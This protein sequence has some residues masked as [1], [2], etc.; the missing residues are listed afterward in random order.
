MARQVQSTSRAP[1]FGGLTLAVAL[2]LAGVQPTSAIAQPANAASSDSINDTASTGQSRQQTGGIEAVPEQDEALDNARDL[3]SG[4]ASYYGDRFA[5]KPTASGEPF[6]PT[7]LTAAHR[8]LP[9]GS[10]VLVTS[11][12]TGKSVIVRINDRGPF[13]AGRIIDLSKAAASRI[14]LVRQG[15]G[16]VNLTLIAE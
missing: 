1:I 14:G 9:F 5:G 15:I 11:Q 12:R 6:D 2:L 16:A 4:I 7:A 10:K 3:G 8:S 13:R